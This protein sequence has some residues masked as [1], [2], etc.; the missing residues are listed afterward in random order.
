MQPAAETLLCPMIDARRMEVYTALFNSSAEMLNTVSAQI[1]DENT[2]KELLNNNK[3]MFFGDG[4]DKCKSVI[5]SSNAIFVEIQSSA[6][7]MIDVAVE[8]FKNS[9]FVDIAYFEPFYLKNFVATT[10]KKK[11][12]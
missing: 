10:S 1:V 9:D 4:A 6:R 11:V 2:Y 5:K 3:I 7:G 12:F 8:K